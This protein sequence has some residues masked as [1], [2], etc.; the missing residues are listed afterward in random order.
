ME[1]DIDNGRCGRGGVVAADGLDGRTEF[2]KGSGVKAALK[3]DRLSVNSQRL[4]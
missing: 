4:R 3:Y 2:T 1:S